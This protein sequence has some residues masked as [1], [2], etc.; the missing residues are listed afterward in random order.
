M[1]WLQACP[2]SGNIFYRSSQYQEIAMSNNLK[3]LLRDR[4]LGVLIRDARLHAGKTLEECAAFLSIEPKKLED[5]ELGRRQVTLPELEA[6]AYLVD[7]PAEH[8]FGN[9]LLD[10][11]GKK[12]PAKEIIDLR[13]RVIGAIIRQSRIQAGL[14]PSACADSLGILERTFLDYELGRTPIPFSELQL[15]SGM[16]NVLPET[17]LDKEFNPVHKKTRRK[18]AVIGHLPQQLQDFLQEPLNA[19]YLETAFRLSKMSGGELRRI[20]ESLL[21]ITY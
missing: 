14:S 16:L 21:E 13:N 12:A 4:V 6:F 3:V 11:N 2:F 19:D 8:F 17:F 18:K 10:R 20:A 9:K 15:L 1:D 7:I 5:I